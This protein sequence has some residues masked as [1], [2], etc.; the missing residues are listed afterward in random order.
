MSAASS[1]ARHPAVVVFD[2]GGTVLDETPPSFGPVADASFSAFSA[3]ELMTH[4]G[5]LMA[6]LM[7][8]AAREAPDQADVASV[9]ATYREA[10]GCQI[11]RDDLEECVWRMIGGADTSYLAPIEP[12]PALLGELKARGVPVVALSNTA[13]PLS[14]LSRLLDAHGLGG[15]FDDV[16]L[17]SE[18]GWR[19]P[20]PQLVEVVE[21]RFPAQASDRWLIVGNDELYDV[22][23]C[24]ARGWSGILVGDEAK[25]GAAKAPVRVADL[26]AARS[27]IHDWL[28]GVGVAR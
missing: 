17:S 23:P 16:V 11:P 19:K 2:L 21:Q 24:L 9:V 18:V 4:T 22:D 25:P 14:L 15:V 6:Y 13:L 10:S 8:E 28:D 20:S 5:G 12:A 1:T 27:A 26:A 3:E 7:R